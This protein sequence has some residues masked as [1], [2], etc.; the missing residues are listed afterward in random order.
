MLDHPWAI[1]LGDEI[2]EIHPEQLFALFAEVAAEDF[3]DKGQRAVWLKPADQLGLVIF[4]DGAVA[5][6]ALAQGAFGIHAAGDVMR[7]V[8]V[9]DQAGWS[10]FR[11]EVRSGAS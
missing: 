5:G 4:N 9:A 6:F 8:H 1:A 2:E 3:V 7:N 10:F 11:L